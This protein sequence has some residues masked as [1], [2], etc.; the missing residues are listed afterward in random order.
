MRNLLFGHLSGS[1][2]S[3]LLQSHRRMLRDELNN[4]ADLEE[5]AQGIC[6]RKGELS[7]K[8]TVEALFS[9]TSRA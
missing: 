2:D 8:G 5:F 1:G 6:F 9:E 3:I 7:W 4:T